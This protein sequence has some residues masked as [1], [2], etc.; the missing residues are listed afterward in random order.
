MPF[1]SHHAGE[2]DLGV[3]TPEKKADAADLEFRVFSDQRSGTRPSPGPSN[4]TYLG[5]ENDVRARIDYGLKLPAEE[6]QKIIEE[7]PLWRGKQR[8]NGT[9]I[10]S[11]VPATYYGNGPY[12]YLLSSIYKLGYEQ[13]IDKVYIKDVSK[14]I[15][16]TEAA[17]KGW[18]DCFRFQCL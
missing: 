7:A 14:R 18:M 17:K 10:S 6:V 15:E 4:Y 8:Y 1:G 11:Q 5:K 12:E 13:G 9:T 3:N 2:G 16:V